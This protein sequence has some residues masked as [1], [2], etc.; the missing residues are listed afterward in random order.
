MDDANHN[1]CDCLP[2]SPPYTIISP[3]FSH[4][5]VGAKICLCPWLNNILLCECTI[6]YPYIWK[7]TF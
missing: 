2:H 4:A 1:L 6:I 3:T 5:A 7:G